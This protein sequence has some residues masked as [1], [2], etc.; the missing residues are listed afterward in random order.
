MTQSD[1]KT[2]PQGLLFFPLQAILILVGSEVC[3]DSY[4]LTYIMMKYFVTDNFKNT[5]MRILP[6]CLRD[7]KW[8][9]Q[10]GKFF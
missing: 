3:T 7:V 2:K 9:C 1:T 10:Y 6:R 4:Q 5:Q 8:G